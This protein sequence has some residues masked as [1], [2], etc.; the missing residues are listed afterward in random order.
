[1]KEYDMP[2]AQL[3]IEKANEYFQFDKLNGPDKP[4]HT[5]FP[6]D[7]SLGTVLRDVGIA[8]HPADAKDVDVANK[9]PTPLAE[10]LKALI[11]NNLKRS[12]PY[13]IQFLWWPAECWGLEVTEVD[14]VDASGSVGGISVLI[15]SPRDPLKP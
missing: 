5:K 4:S 8:R 2:R 12:A 10:S 7:S 11:R 9:M 13:S 3:M 1:M 14:A 6:E 15:K